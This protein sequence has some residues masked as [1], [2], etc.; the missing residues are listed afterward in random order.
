[1]VLRC[2]CLVTLLKVEGVKCQ[3][4]SPVLVVMPLL[5][6]PYIR[7]SDDVIACNDDVV[8]CN[9]NVIAG[10]YDE[11]KSLLHNTAFLKSGFCG[12]F[13]NLEIEAS[14]MVCTLS[15]YRGFQYSFH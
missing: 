7:R 14:A 10:C 6:M 3:E 2:C 4:S 11:C 15:A 12:I 8:A 5:I 13:M 9:D 1:M